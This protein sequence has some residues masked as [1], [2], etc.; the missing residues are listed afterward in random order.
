MI[1]SRITS[2]SGA[3]HAEVWDGAQGFFEV[4][5]ANGRVWAYLNNSWPRPYQA[6]VDYCK[7]KVVARHFPQAPG[8]KRRKDF[9]AHAEYHRVLGK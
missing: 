8:I 9:D 5:T 3:Y 1:R 6:M 7:K 4:R 2:L